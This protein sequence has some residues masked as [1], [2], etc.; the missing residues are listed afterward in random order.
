MRGR[1]GAALVAC[2]AIFAPAGAYAQTM[3]LSSLPEVSLTAEDYREL[4]AAY[5]PL[6]NDDTVPIGTTKEW[7]N[8][9]SENHGTV[10]LVKRFEITFEGAQLPC[11]ALRY[12]I[13]L[14]D[15]AD[16]YNV[17]LNRCKVADGTWKLY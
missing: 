14:K 5:Q 9:K 8:P 16:P 12:H 6:L 7:S 11:R 15:N 10:Q 4:A 2:L 3:G 1:L 17:R 13:I